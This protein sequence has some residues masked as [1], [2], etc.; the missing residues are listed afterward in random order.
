MILL[1]GIT[2]KTGSVAAR[3][4]VGKGLRLRA[5]VRNEEKAKAFKDAG[6]ELIV[7]DAGDDA[8][9]TKA[10]TGVAKALLIM[11]NNEKQAALEEHFVDKA[12]AAGVKHIV[13]M[14]SMEAVPGAKAA[15]P[16]THVRVEAYIRASGLAWTMIRPNFF[17]Q[18]LLGNART[19]KEQGTFSLPCGQGKTGMS[20]T[21]D[22][23]AVI[24]AVLAGQGHEG[25]SY[26]LTG[27]E[28]LSFA[29][30]AQRFSEVL[31]KTVTYIDQPMAEYRAYLGKFL[32]NAWHHN[33]VCELF[34]EIAEGG[35]NKTTDTIE[36]ILGR[37]PT[38]LKQ[39]IVDHIAVFKG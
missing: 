29:D 12:K 32:T 30:V 8:T 23:G 5:I 19:I 24:A 27:P 33:A 21:R 37:K 35:L 2:G 6:I 39:F 1:N 34:G 38:S 26:E 13:K 17:M 16:A 14:S 7:G 10:M 25:Q 11:P 15:I 9:L 4:L 22:V 36:R 28:L 20:D 18:N 31:G 3:A